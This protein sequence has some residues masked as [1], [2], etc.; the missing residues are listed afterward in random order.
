MGAFT[1]LSFWPTCD[2]HISCCIKCNALSLRTL[3]TYVGARAGFAKARNRTQIRSETTDSEL[4]DHDR[5]RRN[6]IR[7]HSKLK[8]QELATNERLEKQANTKS[9]CRNPYDFIKEKVTRFL[10]KLVGLFRSADPSI[11]FRTE[12]GLGLTSVRNAC[13]KAQ[14]SKEVILC[15]S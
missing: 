12:K 5:H 6:L 9:F 10:K 14:V 8:R 4:A 3:R 13:M 1:G 11:L 15:C 7:L 2:T